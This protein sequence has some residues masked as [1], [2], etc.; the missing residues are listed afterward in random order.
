VEFPH[1]PREA[2][3]GHAI[4]TGAFFESGK[5]AMDTRELN[6]RGLK[7]RKELFGSDAVDK[8]MQEFGEFGAPLQ[9]IIN[10]YI[11][12]D[13][14]SRSGLSLKQRSLAMLG[15]TAASNHAN[16]FRVHVQGALKNG[17]TQEEIREVLLL[18]AM[19]C[20]VPSAIDAHRIALEVFKT[21][22]VDR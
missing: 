12:G 19:Y 16:E 6:E 2:G 4:N 10:A 8:R 7:L 17:C 14:W 9:H 18:V 15:I 5:V 21:K 20:G 11:Y 13:V 3:S 22:S 1:L